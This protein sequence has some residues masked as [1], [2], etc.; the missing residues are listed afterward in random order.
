MKR[1]GDIQSYSRFV[2]N[3]LINI[4]IDSRKVGRQTKLRFRARKIQE[5]EISE[6]QEV[7]T[8][9][10]EQL[11]EERKDLDAMMD[12]IVTCYQDPTDS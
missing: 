7:T 2:R 9:S 4:L 5:I 10:E 1:K 3:L 11:N 8:S 12:A 6:V